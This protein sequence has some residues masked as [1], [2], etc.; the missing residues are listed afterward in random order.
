MR[1][2]PPSQHPTS[3]GSAATHRGRIRTLVGKLWEGIRANQVLLFNAASMFGSILVTSGLGVLYW[4]VAAQFFDQAAVGLSSTLISTMILLGTVGM[5]GLGTLLMGEIPRHPADAPALL[6]TALVAAT[7]MGGLLGV[8]FGVLAPAWSDEFAVFAT[9]PLTI[10]LFAAGVGLTASTL[11]LDHALFGMLRGDLQLWRNGVFAFIKLVFLIIVGML[12]IDGSGMLI[13]NT[14]IL[15]IVVSCVVFI[16]PLSRSIAHW[17]GW[18]LRWSMLRHLG[19]SALAHHTLNLALEAPPRIVPLIIT[20][21]HSPE[22]AASFYIAWMVAA[23]IFMVPHSLTTMLYAV[24][25]AE[26]K[27]LARKLRFTLRMSLLV[28]GAL[29]AGTLISA[30]LL[31]GIFGANYVDQA[32][33]A[34]RLFAIG[35]LFGIV[36]PH[37]IAV[38]RVQQRVKAGLPYIILF[39]VSEV[40]CATIGFL[41]G[42]LTGL[43]VGWL[44]S[45]ILEALVLGPMMFRVVQQSQDA[46]GNG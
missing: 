11:V 29:I 27:L 31:L 44:V 4:V 18:Q 37:F 43:G 2:V 16:R 35:A 17:Q 36:K 13:Y 40:V 41:Y 14:W 6:L 21:L 28:V 20:S 39:S 45:L 32:G 30:D 23:L 12:V 3:V 10:G 26:P 15:G 19:G 22:I 24:S 8:L 1:L 25:A 46:P 7:A 9:Q 42:G 38:Y 33:G 34:L 5:M